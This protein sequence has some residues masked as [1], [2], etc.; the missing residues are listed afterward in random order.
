MGDQQ[1]TTNDTVD[2]GL[3]E[4]YNQLFTSASLGNH[5]H[6]LAVCV[7][8]LLIGFESGFG[9]RLISVFREIWSTAQ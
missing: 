4:V 7:A 8:T 1:R 5:M 3:T 6:G 9:I 2:T